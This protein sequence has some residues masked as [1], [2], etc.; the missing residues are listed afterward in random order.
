MKI[1]HI[2]SFTII[3][4]L[5]A[6]NS[7]DSTVNEVEATQKLIN[8][9]NE[10]YVGFVIDTLREERWYRDKEIFEE[11]IK[12]LGGNVKTLAANGDQNVQVEQ[13]KLLINEG[14][15]VLVVVPTD[16][17]DASEIVHM[18]HDADVKVISYDRLILDADVDYYLS[19]DNEKVGKL[20]A[21]AILEK[22]SSGNFAYVGGAE[23]DNNSKLLREGSLQVLQRLIDNGEI[24]LVY[25]E[26]TDNWSPDVAK[27]NII[28]FMEETDQGLDAVIAAND[29]TAGGVIE[30]FG[31]QAGTIPI[32]GQDAELA[33]L[34]RIVAGTQTMTVYKSI[35]L[36]AKEAAKLAIDVG[37]NETITTDTSIKN[38][39]KDVPSILLDPISVTKENIQETV[40]ADGVYG[41]KEIFE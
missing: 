33:A 7:S 15:D 31:D 38:G 5:V 32:S 29:G 6:C 16:A 10:L 14:V 25:N 11:E 1:L 28:Q 17:S 41:E 19:F 3:F 12:S 2:L 37:N 36:I 22:V 8:N 26:F 13:A 34:Q 9:Q 27:E 20:Q 23:S 21:E 18:A 30:A 40:I 39:N 35:S 4:V 24:E